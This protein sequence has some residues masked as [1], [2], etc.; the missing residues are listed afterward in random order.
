MAYDFVRAPRPG[1]WM[2][3][4]AAF[5]MCACGGGTTPSSSTNATPGVVSNAPAP[6]PAPAPS[7]SPAPAPAP[8]PAQ[9]SAAEQLLPAWARNYAPTT[10]I[11]VSPTGN[12]ASSGLSRAT[13]LKTTA[14]AVA[15]LAPGVRLNFTAG[16]YGCAGGYIAGFNGGTASPGSIRS[17]DGPRAAKF[18]CANPDGSPGGSF[19]LDFV[20]GFIFEGIELSN[21]SGHGIQVMSGLGPTWNVNTISSD[22][23]LH[24]S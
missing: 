9:L 12:D 1:A 23:V 10:E 3:I 11:Y 16:T 15:K 22:I 2:S 19:L 7:S 14:A 13:A 6:A 8:A 24:G 18:N 17:I 4:V 20:H 21:S 5:A